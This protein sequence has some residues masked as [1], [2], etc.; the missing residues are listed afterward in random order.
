MIRIQKQEMDDKMKELEIKWY[1]K[2]IKILHNRLHIIPKELPDS[3]LEGC[4]SERP[5]ESPLQLLCHGTEKF[6]STKAT[7]GL[8]LANLDLYFKNSRQKNKN[9]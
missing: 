4:V 3:Y 9:F 6:I 2:Q 1:K 8:S 7:C 5:A